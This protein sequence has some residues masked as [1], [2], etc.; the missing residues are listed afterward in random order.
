[1]NA[2]DNRAA[3]RANWQ[4]DQTSKLKTLGFTVRPLDL[5]DYFG[6]PQPMAETLAVL[7]LVWVN[8]GNAF[9]LRRA[10]QRSG[11]D[12]AL[13]AALA[14]DELVYAGFSAAAVVLPASL[15]GLDLV[16]DPHNVPDGYPA[17]VPWE[18]LNILLFGCGALELRSPGSGRRA[19]GN[20]V[21]SAEWLSIQDFARWAGV[22]HRA[23]Q[24]TRRAA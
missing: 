17:E 11:F 6:R 4:A 15:R 19:E 23:W 5:R 20:R 12:V 7:D 24:G 2:L 16:D 13:R 8:G 21:P 18:G 1:M 22:D 14:N 3:A 9:V 10:M